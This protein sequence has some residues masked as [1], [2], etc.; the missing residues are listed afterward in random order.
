MT[1]LI[2][3]N[4]LFLILFLLII[5]KEPFYKIFKLEDNIYNPLKCE[6]LENDYNKLLEFNEIDLV[7]NMEFIN[8]Y[9]IYKDIFDYMN[10]FTIRGGKNEGFINN[11]VVYDNTLIGVIDKV[12]DNS[13]IVKLL[14]NKTSQISVKIN[15]EVG[16]LEY[17]NGKLIVSNISNYGNINIGDNIYTSGLGN[18]KENIYIGEVLNIELNNKNI[19]QII[20]VDYKLDIKDIDYVTVLKESK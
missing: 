15:E 11:P 3:E 17:K 19:E 8:T 18:I 16:L 4:Y 20:T 5:L 9:I 13:S 2:K 12:N 10:E 6:F 14:S 7:Y 1:K